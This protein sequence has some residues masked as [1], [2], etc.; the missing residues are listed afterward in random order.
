LI[1][2][3]LGAYTVYQALPS[4]RENPRLRSI[5]TLYVLSGVANIVWLFL[6]HYEVFEFTLVAMVALLVSLILIYLRLDIGRVSVSTAEKWTVDIPFSIYLGWVTV[7]TIAN[8]T[9]LL[10]YLGWNG[11][12]IAPE[13]WAVIML[14]V[15]VLVS[16]VVSFSRGDIAY[17]LVL[18]W[19]YIGIAREQAG[20]PIVVY[21][22][23]IGVVLI[24]VLLVLAVFQRRGSA[25]A[26][27][28]A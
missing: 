13:I 15:G 10:F 8:V 26:L 3:G 5:G 7:A 17:S 11:W 18:I 19:A 23:W 21:S 4:Q 16:G 28:P 22:A 24:L 27:Q 2:I 25:E 6:W 12:G 20:A 1:Y 14:A 9:Q